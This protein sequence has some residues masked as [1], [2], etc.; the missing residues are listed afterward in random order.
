[1]LRRWETYAFLPGTAPE[2]RQRLADVLLGA[3]QYIP[4]VLG[5]A[6][7]WNRSAVSSELVW[8]HRFESPAAYQRYMVHAYHAD[9]IDRYVLADSPERIVET[10]KG[11]GL[12]GYRCDE[13]VDGEPPWRVVILLQI[14]PEAD[15]STEPGLWHALAERAAALGAQGIGFGAN[16]LANA[17]FDGVT[18]LPGPPPRWT[19]VW[20]AGLPAEV[21][22]SEFDGVLETPAVRARRQL[23]YQV[24]R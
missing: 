17:W 11:A 8:E 22:S 24:V 10:V 16:S 6:V 19:H 18:P 23:L 1:M 15:D 13:A 12:F 3:G 20:E 9:L 7:G 21:L 14:A 5:S 2:L 4:E